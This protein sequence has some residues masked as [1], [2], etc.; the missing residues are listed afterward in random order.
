MP[1]THWLSPLQKVS[2]HSSKWSAASTR[3]ARSLTVIDDHLKFKSQYNN[4]INYLNS[5]HDFFQPNRINP[6]NSVNPTKV[7]NP[8]FFPQ[9]NFSEF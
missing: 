3:L 6:T 7:K 9:E 2:L 1:H 8:P 5:K 4:E